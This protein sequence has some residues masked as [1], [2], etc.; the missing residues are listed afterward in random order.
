MGFADK[1]PTPLSVRNAVSGQSND[2]YKNEAEAIGFDVG[3]GVAVVISLAIHAKPNSIDAK[4]GG[5]AVNR[6]QIWKSET[7]AIWEFGGIHSCVGKSAGRRGL[8]AG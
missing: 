8:R 6:A 2:R 7:D 1:E 4:Q 3:R 5:H